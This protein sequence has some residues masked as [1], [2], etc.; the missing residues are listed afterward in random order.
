ML[1]LRRTLDCSVC[2]RP[3]PFGNT[4]RPSQ[5]TSRMTYDISGA[6][7]IVKRVAAVET[8]TLPER[9]LVILFKL[10]SLAPLCFSIA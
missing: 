1:L 8:S 7:R 10:I 6:S 9:C 4:L 5:L 2:G 3:C